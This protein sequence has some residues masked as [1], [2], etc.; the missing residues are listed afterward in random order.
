MLVLDRELEVAAS[1]SGR[2]R[3]VAPARAHWSRQPLTLFARTVDDIGAAEAGGQAIASL[4]SG[5]RHTVAWAWASMWQRAAAGETAGPDRPLDA[6]S[7]HDEDDDRLGKLKTQADTASG[8][9]Q[10]EDRSD[11]R[12]LP[13]RTVRRRCR[14]AS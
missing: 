8:A 13:Q 6:T 11:V 2:R 1:V 7:R 9:Q 12:R 3:L 10:E 4:F 14:F 5:A